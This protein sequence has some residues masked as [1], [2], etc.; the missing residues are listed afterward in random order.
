[1]KWHCIWAIMLKCW[2]ITINRID[3]WFDIF[4]WP[5]LGLFLWG[6]TS[7]YLKQFTGETIVYYFLGGTILWVFFQRSQQDI[8]L[9]ILEDFWSHNLYNIFASP[10]R[11][12][13]LVIGVL[14]FGVL[15]AI[16]SFIVLFILG[17]ALYSFNIFS[18]GILYVIIFALGLLLFA[19]G[20]G[21]LIS[22]A[23]FRWGTRIQVFCWSFSWL[24]QPF[25]CVYYP[26][27][28]LPPIAQSIAVLLPT[29]HI[30]E[31]FR[32]AMEHDAIKWD[33]MLYAFGANLI[34]LVIAGWI[35]S[36]SL[37]KAREKG[38]LTKRGE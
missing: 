19:W 11:G 36:A 37:N 29:T 18:V 8:P 24:V 33:S 14:S 13:E 7:I 25:S 30:F 23:I 20:V 17:I 21:V 12:I 27:S 5:T 3:R 32:Y 9:F 38:L 26:L 16:A 34:F 4:Y 2:Y 15:R 31:G 28:S 22:A 10:L 1:M 6:F 35:F